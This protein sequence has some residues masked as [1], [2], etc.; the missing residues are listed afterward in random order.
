[1]TLLKILPFT[2][3][4]L[5]FSGS[6]IYQGSNVVKIVLKEVRIKLMVLIS[7]TAPGL[8]LPRSV[9]DCPFFLINLF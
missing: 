1:M 7:P 8:P 4:D 9:E 2:R 5:L 6:Q 3:Q